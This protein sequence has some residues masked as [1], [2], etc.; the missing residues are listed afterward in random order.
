ML[1]LQQSL[2]HVLAYSLLLPEL[3]QGK[4]QYNIHPHVQIP[5]GSQQGSRLSMRDENAAGA[6]GSTCQEDAA[7]TCAEGL[8]CSCLALNRGLHVC[9]PEDQA[10]FVAGNKLERHGLSCEPYLP[11]GLSV[12]QAPPVV[13]VQDKVVDPKSQAALKAWASG[14]GQGVY[15]SY[16]AVGTKEGLAAGTGIPVLGDKGMKRERIQWAASVLKHLLLNAT[17]NPKL[18]PTLAQ[19]NIRLLLDSGKHMES[20][21]KKHPEVGRRLKTGLGGGAPW[22]PST[23]ILQD[24]SANTLAEEMFHTIQ[25]TVLQPR[26]VCMYHKAYRNAHTSKLYDQDGSSGEVDGEPVPTVQADEYL[27]MAFQRWM[28][29]DTGVEEEYL[30]QGNNKDGTGRE[31]L[32]AKDPQAF[33][34]LSTMWRS[35]DDWNPEPDRVPWANFANKPMD[36]AEVSSFCAPVLEQLGNGCPSADVSWPY[37]TQKKKL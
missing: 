25:Y 9:V 26:D 13:D 35:D 30:V 31:H 29:S 1:V 12:M 37:L 20:S 36:R 2:G 10:K 11:K 15:G 7:G 19:H 23:G 17:V 6:E 22:F 4:R 27:A 8:V 34:L 18:L 32:K 16:A 5:G 24:E 3:L 14:A 33:C 28:G 21:W